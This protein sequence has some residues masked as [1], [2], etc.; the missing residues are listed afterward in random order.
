MIFVQK[1]LA[2]NNIQG[3]ISRSQTIRKDGFNKRKKQNIVTRLSKGNNNVSGKV[4]DTGKRE[5]A[6]QGLGFFEDPSE[7]ANAVISTKSDGTPLTISDIGEVR[8]SGLFRRSVLADK[9]SEKVGGIVVM[10][11]EENPLEVIEAV[12]EEIK[13][14]EKSLPAGI[15]IKGFYEKK[16]VR[17][18]F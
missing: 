14:V 3:L 15:E 2:Q 17:S 12:K 7:I 10:R 11:Y 16:T 8:I 1:S 18:P 4:I 5:V 9:D 6:V 13:R